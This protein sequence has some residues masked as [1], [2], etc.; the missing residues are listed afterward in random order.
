[1]TIAYNLFFSDCLCDLERDDCS[2]QK[3]YGLD[4]L[5][6]GSAIQPGGE[7]DPCFFCR[8]GDEHE[9]RAGEEGR[10]TSVND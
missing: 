10:H 3:S 5:L 6:R 1:M 7:R 2:G 9:C 4:D 8:D